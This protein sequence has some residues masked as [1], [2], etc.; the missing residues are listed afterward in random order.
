MQALQADWNSR[1]RGGRWNRC[2]SSRV[3]DIDLEIASPGQPHAQLSENARYGCTSYKMEA[4]LLRYN[5]SLV[6]VKIFK[7]PASFR[8]A[9]PIV[10]FEVA[11]PRILWRATSNFFL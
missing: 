7:P 9:T 5:K 10:C 3:V 1:A 2:R 8:T 4:K 6:C 11:G